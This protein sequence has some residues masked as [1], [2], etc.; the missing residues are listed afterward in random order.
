MI[1]D[2]DVIA[3][4]LKHR[5]KVYF[6]PHSDTLAQLKRSENAN[7]DDKLGELI[8]SNLHSETNEPL[9]PNFTSQADFAM[10]HTAQRI[11]K[12]NK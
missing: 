10:N 5:N 4:C 8:K 3:P 12:E 7:T 2:S 1:K 9:L 11:Y 6:R